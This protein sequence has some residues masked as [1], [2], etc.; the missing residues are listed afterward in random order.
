M[1]ASKSPIVVPDVPVAGRGPLRLRM[2]GPR[3]SGHLDGGWWPYSRDLVVELADLVDH[4][5]ARSGQ[6][7]RA[8]V[9][10]PDW[11]SAPRSIP[12]ARGHLKVGSF[13]R[14]DTHLILLTTSDR[15]V[16]RVMVVPPGLTREQG[17]EALL[18]SA[19][20]GNTH[21]GTDVLDEVTDHPATDPRDHWTDTGDSWWG[22]GGEA[23]SFRTGG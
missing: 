18:A 16:L 4:F 3:G 17:E 8:L 14:D 5:P 21:S 9:S 7:V 12:V 13:P 15:I 10:P 22:S 6:I 19:T 23:P 1:A 2:A 20:A 11:D